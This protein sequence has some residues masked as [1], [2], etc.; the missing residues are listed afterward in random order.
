[1]YGL[2]SLIDRYLTPVGETDAA[3]PGVL[4]G[5]DS[6]LAQHMVHC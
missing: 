6:S 5:V 1:M 3:P 2:S 4:R